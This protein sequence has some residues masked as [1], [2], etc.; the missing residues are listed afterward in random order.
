MHIRIII[1]FIIITMS[2]FK[3]VGQDKNVPCARSDTLPIYLGVLEHNERN[4][5]IRLTFSCFHNKWKTLCKNYPVIG[6]MDEKIMVTPLFWSAIYKN[7]ICGQLKSLGPNKLQFNLYMIKSMED[8][9]KVGG[10]DTYY[11]G[12]LAKPKY[13]PLV[14]IPGGVNLKPL[15]WD[16]VELSN[17]ERK[18]IIG[19]YRKLVGDTI[20]ICSLNEQISDSLI[21]YTYS[22]NDIII[23][24]C[25][26]IQQK[27]KIVSLQLNTVLNHCDGPPNKEWST[28]WF[29]IDS[30]GEIFHFGLTH[31]RISDYEIMKLVDMGD[32]NGDG[33]IEALFWRERYNE[34]GYVLFF[35][36][37]KC[38]VNCLW[39]YH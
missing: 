26:S 10:L 15:Q 18:N 24:S 3:C 17:I 12:W 30:V 16:S 35:N 6:K 38:S 2:L 29:M 33:K 32:F 5:Y 4:A 13:R 22:D 37:F 36:D 7:K 19:S 23:S 14:V 27:I 34:D 39:N 1:S 25:Y 20:R 11:S 28:Y 9:P 31:S 8:T 21:F